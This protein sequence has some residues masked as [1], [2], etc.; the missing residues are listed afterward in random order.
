MSII[1]PCYN[2]EEAIPLFYNEISKIANLL[3]T[4]YKLIT[5]C[6]IVNDGS[7]DETLKTIKMLAQ[8]DPILKY[9]SFS[10]N[11]G[12]ES[13]IYAGLEYST[14]DFVAIM[15]VDLQDPPE[16]L[17]EMYLS[18]I[19]ENFDCVA[20]RRVTR[21]G[22][23]PI[24][25]FFA[26]CFYKLINKMS[27]IEIVDGAR[28]YRLMTRQMVDAIINVKEYNRFSKGI[29]SWVGFETKWLEYENRERIA[30][31]TKWSFWKLFLYSL[32]GIVA[33]TTAPL[34]IASIVGVLC[35]FIAII[36]IG[37]FIIKTII[38][39]DPVAGYPSMICVILLIGGLQLFCI[40]ILGEYLAKTYLETKK[41]PIYIMKEK[42]KN[43]KDK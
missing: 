42:S 20:T 40:G 29:F 5:E 6:I 13:A 33:Y 36:M 27:K 21:K 12:K 34:A 23:P 30:G 41:R 10:R 38:W 17:E 39:G 9:I 31:E 32:D 24:R 37:V 16:L 18:I 8:N 14:G 4:K 2:E 15:D 26:R 3:K 1:V 28:D 19:N 35:C 22:E 11:F 43:E 25:S 7:S